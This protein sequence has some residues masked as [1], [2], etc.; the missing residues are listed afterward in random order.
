MSHP[1]VAE[2]VCYV[3]KLLTSACCILNHF[4]VSA[5]SRWPSRKLGSRHCGKDSLTQASEQLDPTSL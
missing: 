2:I 5:E 4:Y 3:H 1:R